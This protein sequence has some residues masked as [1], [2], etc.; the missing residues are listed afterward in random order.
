MNHQILAHYMADFEEE[1]RLIDIEI[2]KNKYN[3]SASN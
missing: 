2:R 3:D 1:S